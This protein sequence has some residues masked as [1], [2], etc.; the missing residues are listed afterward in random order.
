MEYTK[1]KD[2]NDPSICNM[3]T[4]YLKEMDVPGTVNYKMI[5]GEDDLEVIKNGNYVAIP[6]F[7]GTPIWL[8]VFRKHDVYYAVTFPKVFKNSKYNIKV[9]PIK[10][11]FPSSSYKGSIM[12]GTY[13]QDR[14]V[15]YVIINDA[16]YLSGK[17]LA[18]MSRE[19]RLA[20]ALRHLGKCTSTDENYKMFVSIHY[21][22]NKFSLSLLF[23]KIKEDNNVTHVCFYPQQMDTEAYEYV[24]KEEDKVEHLVKKGIF[25]MVKGKGPDVYHLCFIDSDRKMELAYIPNITV[26]KMCSGW[27]KKDVKKVRASCNYD[28]VSGKYIPVELVK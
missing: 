15:S 16:Y 1:N 11:M 9:Y 7:K 21:S 2:L 8:C 6:R 4:G 17:N 12:E 27:F 5:D 20:K 3:I 19:T 22:L 10:M 26:S 14:G 25:D 13:C 28:S 23:D 18:L 24:V